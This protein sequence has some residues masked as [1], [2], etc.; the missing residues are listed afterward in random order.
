MKIVFLTLAGLFATLL[1][2][3]MTMAK[4]TDATNSSIYDFTENTITGEKKSL[5]D[6]KGKVILIVNTASKCGFTPQF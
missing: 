1:Q 4:N 2:G 6:Y 3:D 5:S